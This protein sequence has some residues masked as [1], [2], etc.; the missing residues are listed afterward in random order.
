MAP[1]ARA[2]VAIRREEEKA[3]SWV[4][5]M[6]ASG[7]AGRRVKV[8]RARRG[9]SGDEVCSARA[10]ADRAEMGMPAMAA[11]GCRAGRASTD[12]VGGRGE[13]EDVEVVERDPFR[14]LWV[15]ESGCIAAE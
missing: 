9:R 12:M 5:A 4:L 11:K 6:C 10:G 14:I 3:W 2:V 1:G 7:A 8:G 13:S 15:D